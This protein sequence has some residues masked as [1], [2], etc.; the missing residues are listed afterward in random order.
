MTMPH[1]KRP[2]RNRVNK[3]RAKKG[4]PPLVDHSP[5]IAEST[6][7]TVGVTSMMIPLT[8]STRQMLTK[9]RL[10]QQRRDPS[11]VASDQLYA[12]AV[13]TAILLQLHEVLFP[14]LIQ[15]P[16][17]QAMGEAKAIHKT[18]ARPFLG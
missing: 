1:S 3:I 4:L 9:I 14:S 7:G 6:P 10:E 16:T 2:R 15:A 13:L 8:T 12:S 5:F 11:T 17:T 18:L